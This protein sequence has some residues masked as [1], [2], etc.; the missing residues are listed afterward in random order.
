MTLALVLVAVI[1]GA[2]VRHFSAKAG[3]ILTKAASG[4]GG[5]FIIVAIIVGS[6]TEAAIFSAS[7][8]LY[9]ASIILLPLGAACGYGICHLAGLPPKSCRTISLETGLQN[10][11]LGLTILSFTFSGDQFEEAAVYALLYSLFL[12]IEGVLISA[13]FAWLARQAG[14]AL[15]TSSSGVELA[16]SSEKEALDLTSQG[17][18]DSASS[19]SDDVDMAEQVPTEQVDV[20]PV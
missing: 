15:D 8:K 9:A 6:V 14:P 17:S 11:T 20:L 16:T 18:N 19:C 5:A 13:L 4:L 1:V 10:S 7:W 3:A 12:V 2:A